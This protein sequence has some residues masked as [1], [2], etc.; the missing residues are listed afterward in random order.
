MDELP[1]DRIALYPAR[2][3]D[4]ARLLVVHPPSPL[5]QI[6]GGEAVL[7]LVRTPDQNVLIVTIDTLRADAVGCYGGRAATPDGRR[8][9]VA[10]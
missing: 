3:R 4:A 5:G 2:P 10:G 7:D 6:A 8:S 1:D 9:P